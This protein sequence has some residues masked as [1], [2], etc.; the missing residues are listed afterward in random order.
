[1]IMTGP[2]RHVNHAR[3]E[4]AE[5]AHVSEGYDVGLARTPIRA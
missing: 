1:M 5:I 2:V 3:P 4:F